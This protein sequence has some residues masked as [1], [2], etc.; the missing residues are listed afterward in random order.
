MKI[1]DKFVFVISILL[2]SNAY[3]ALTLKDLW[4]TRDQQG[5]IFFQK[6]NLK[7]AARIFKNKN[8]QGVASYRAGDYD[9]AFALFHDQK[10][11]DGQYNA[12]NAAAYLGNFKDALKAYDRSIALN[13]NNTDAIFNRELLKKIMDKEKQQKKQ[14][15]KQN[16]CSCANP[17]HSN[18]HDQESKN[19]NNSSNPQSLTANENQQ[20]PKPDE[21]KSTAKDDDKKQQIAKAKDQ[22]EDQQKK[23]SDLHSITGNNKKPSKGDKIPAKQE[24]NNN[25]QNQLPNKNKPLPFGSLQ[26]KENQ[27][28]LLRRLADDPGGLLRQKFLRDYMR[29]HA[30]ENEDEGES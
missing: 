24:F 26:G 5:A 1:I 23:D 12:G 20:N 8:W 25:E 27:K 19:K 6:G 14:E 9:R 21:R 22:K 4:H 10:T 15:K 2:F 30:V 11:S 17:K 28:Q 3:S 16:S 18:P 13:P 7:E 29:R